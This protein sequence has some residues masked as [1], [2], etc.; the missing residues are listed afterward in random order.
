L[1]EEVTAQV[2][3]LAEEKRQELSIEAAARIEVMADRIVLRQAL[4]NLLD[5]AIKHS[6]EGGRVRVLVGKRAG[7]PLI[8]VI[9]NGPGIPLE[10]QEAIFQRFYRVDPA[11]ARSAGGVGLGLCIARWAVE[12][13]GGRIEL[14]SEE[15]KGSTFRIVCAAPAPDD[16]AGP[17]AGS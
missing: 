8:E 9:D 11:R 16:G 3:V 17:R 14:E 4:L 12:L 7:I 15:G 1:A 10:H 5:N 13:H 2:E 6:P